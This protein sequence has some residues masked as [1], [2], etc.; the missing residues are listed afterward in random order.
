MQNTEKKTRFFAIDF[1]WS[2]MN[3]LLTSASSDGTAQIWSSNTGQNIRIIKDNYGCAVNAC[4]FMP[5]NNNLIIVSFSSVLLSANYSF[6]TKTPR[7]FLQNTN[8]DT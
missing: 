1:D 5:L 4:R 8:C 2:I 3:D 7:K 6:Y